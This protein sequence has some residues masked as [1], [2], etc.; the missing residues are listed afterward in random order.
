MVLM[1]DAAF[2]CLSG[3]GPPFSRW[4]TLRTLARMPFLQQV[5]A[6][7]INDRIK[8]EPKHRLRISIKFPSPQDPRSQQECTPASRLSSESDLCMWAGRAQYPSPSAGRNTP[9][10]FVL[11]TLPARSSAVHM[12]P[13]CA[14]VARGHAGL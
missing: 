7:I 4:A 2:E 13:V 11:H 5:G 3:A 9:A 14:F 10:V 8:T 6:A 1:T 12:A